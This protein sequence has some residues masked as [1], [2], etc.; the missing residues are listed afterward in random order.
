MRESSQAFSHDCI[1]P[2]VRTDI[3]LL[4][5]T[6]SQ[7]KTRCWLTVTEGARPTK[8]PEKIRLLTIAP[9]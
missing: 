2:G 8:T 4:S 3:P 9:A 6:I 5:S 7:A 1:L